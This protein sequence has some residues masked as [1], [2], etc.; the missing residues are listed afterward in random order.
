M[1]VFASS[2]P[3]PTA[4]STQHPRSPDPIENFTDKDYSQFNQL[5]FIQ[6]GPSASNAPGEEHLDLLFKDPDVSFITPGPSM[7]ASPE[8]QEN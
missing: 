5:V 4:V 6:G 3:P 2:C 1:F 7:G 8:E